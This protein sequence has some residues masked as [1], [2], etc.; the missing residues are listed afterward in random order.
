MLGL[1]R[2]G[3]KSPA[4]VEGD[5]RLITALVDGKPR[6]VLYRPVVP[7]TPEAERVPFSSPS[8]T[9]YHDRVTDISAEVTL[10]LGKPNATRPPWAAPDAKNVQNG[11]TIELSVPLKALGLSPRPG[12]EIAGDLGILKGDGSRTT[13]RVCWHNQATALTQ[14]VP[15]EA[16]LTPTLWGLWKFAQ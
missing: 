6:A 8:R 4:A 13:F 7:G 2:P 1:N 9:I 15:G 14:D 11:T 16:I 3:N 10:A 5:L 12:L